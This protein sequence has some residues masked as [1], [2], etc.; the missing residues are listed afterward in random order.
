[1][2]RLSSQNSYMDGSAPETAYHSG[3]NLQQF[4]H[5]SGVVTTAVAEQAL[6]RRALDRRR[7]HGEEP[8]SATTP[9]TAWR[10]HLVDENPSD[11]LVH[12][13]RNSCVSASIGVLLSELPPEKRSDD[14]VEGGRSAGVR[15][16]ALSRQRCRSSDRRSHVVVTGKVTVE[17]LGDL[18]D[19]F[20][21]RERLF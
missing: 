20:R 13:G 2:S 15:R 19:E 11:L 14:G 9:A 10:E 7:R 6:C 12:E 1:M 3:P 17:D 5:D 16:L 21:F 18:I 8:L 4:W